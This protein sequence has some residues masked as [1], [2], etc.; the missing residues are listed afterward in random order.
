MNEKILNN[1]CIMLGGV[2]DNLYRNRSWYSGD[3]V[4]ASNG[5]AATL[6][7]EPCGRTG[8][9]TCLYLVEYKIKDDNR[10]IQRKFC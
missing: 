2:T 5:I 3:R 4:Y 10:C 6:T 7:A 9:Y 8:R 1:E